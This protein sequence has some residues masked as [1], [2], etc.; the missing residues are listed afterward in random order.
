MISQFFLCGLVV[1]T[2]SS[3]H[4]DSVSVESALKFLDTSFESAE[5]RLSFVKTSEMYD[6]GDFLKSKYF[7]SGEVKI[8][9]C[10]HFF[11]KSHDN[12][13]YHETI[14]GNTK[15]S[16]RDPYEGMWKQGELG[17]IADFK[18]KA[19]IFVN[20]WPGDE[21]FRKIFVEQPPFS[22]KYGLWVPWRIFACKLHELPSHAGFKTTTIPAEDLQIFRVEGDFGEAT[23]QISNLS[24][25]PR[26]TNIAI[27]QKP[28]SSV[29]SDSDVKI[30]D[31][32]QNKAHTV[33]RNFTF[34][35]KHNEFGAI[36]N[37]SCDSIDKFADGAKNYHS[38]TIDVKKLNQIDPSQYHQTETFKNRR[39]IPNGTQVHATTDELRPIKMIWQD[40]KIVNKV[41]QAPV[42]YT[43]SVEFKPKTGWPNWLYIVLSAA[44]VFVAGSIVFLWRRKRAQRGES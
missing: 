35:I 23:F 14:A 39:T 17:F 13:T 44:C 6:G 30:K 4:V 31:V 38:L 43:E 26:V 21:R 20:S 27:L 29:L 32:V 25:N 15:K 9:N 42:Q 12:C 36:T 41:D 33:S 40:G 18:P 11:M 16:T 7:E 24:R 22:P 28:E 5:I 34:T 10:E 1:L 2:S 19:S 8:I 37:Y 3:S